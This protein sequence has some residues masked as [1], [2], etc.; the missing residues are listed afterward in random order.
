MS[1]LAKISILG[2]V[3]IFIFCFS[4]S[5]FIK[6]YSV[7][8]FVAMSLVFTSNF[9]LFSKSLKLKSLLPKSSPLAT[10][11]SKWVTSFT[12]VS[13]LKGLTA[14]SKSKSSKSMSILS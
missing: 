3:S 10:E 9:K 14:P 5:F 11:V 2:N 13:P 12:F 8:F 6:L 7:N 1:P 4:S